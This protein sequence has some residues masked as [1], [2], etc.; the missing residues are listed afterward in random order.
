MGDS[1]Q[2]QVRSKTGS[3]YKLFHTDSISTVQGIYIYNANIMI[4]STVTYNMD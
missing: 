2:Q 1:Y 3:T 4:T